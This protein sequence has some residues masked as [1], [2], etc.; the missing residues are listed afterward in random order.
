MRYL[1]YTGMHTS[2]ERDDAPYDVLLYLFGLYR[3]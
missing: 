3:R 2:I 1:R